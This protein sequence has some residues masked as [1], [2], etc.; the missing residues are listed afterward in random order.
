MA[1]IMKNCIDTRT[2]PAI[3]STLTD[4]QW[5]ELKRLL[6]TRLVKTEQTVLNWKNGKTYPGDHTVRKEVCSILNRF[7]NIKTSHLTL[8][9]YERP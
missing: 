6:M 7:L 5:L 4:L 8:F 1:N 3:C 2:F 9:D